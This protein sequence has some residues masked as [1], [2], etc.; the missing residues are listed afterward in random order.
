M[1]KIDLSDES[2]F[3]H[4]LSMEH[5]PS[6]EPMMMI[7]S[8]ITAST[9]ASTRASRTSTA[10]IA[11]LTTDKESLKDAVVNFVGDKAKTLSD[12]TRKKMMAK[13]GCSFF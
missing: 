5:E 10:T 4:E 1:V 6:D 3:G 13:T 12:I 9:I 2:E 7:S 8:T 11:Q